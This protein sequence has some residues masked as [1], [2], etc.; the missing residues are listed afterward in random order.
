MTRQP[1]II[2]GIYISGLL[3]ISATF[4]AS[5]LLL[6]TPSKPAPIETS[7]NTC[8]IIPINVAKKKF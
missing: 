3:I 1:K 6:I 8:G 2:R 7:K 5:K 4:G